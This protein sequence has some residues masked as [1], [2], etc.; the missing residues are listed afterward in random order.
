MENEYTLYTYSANNTYYVGVLKPFPADME[1]Y[2]VTRNGFADIA[3][4]I[5]NLEV[6]EELVMEA[7]EAA[8]I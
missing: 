3:I 2:Q 6:T 8:K 4:I 7:I 1:H 5:A